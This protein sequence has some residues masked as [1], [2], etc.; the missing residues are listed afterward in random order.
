MSDL[1]T[2]EF[3]AARHAA[4]V[5]KDGFK[6]VDDTDPKTP[7]GHA[8]GFRISSRLTSD[9]RRQ[10]K[11]HTVDVTP[12]EVVDCLR[13]A[14]IKNWVL[15]GLHGYVGYLPMPRATQDVDV[16]VPL[17]QKKATLKAIQTQWPTLETIELPQV[18]RF[19]DPAD[20]LDG[21]PLPIIDVMLPLE[22]FQKT[23]LKKYIVEDQE[24]GTYVPTVEAA[25]VAKYAP[26][27]SHNRSWDKKQQDAIDFRRIVR[28]NFQRLDRKVIHDLAD[29][30]WLGGGAELLS[31][32]E[33]AMEDK[34]FPI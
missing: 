32:L 15:M 12:Q 10:Y 26:L 24:T 33:I 13:A 1:H 25:I 34:L 14:K 22:D 17:S 28:A 16:M 6:G 4:M 27:I 3:L 9:Y 29:Q 5:A 7:V 20:N 19:Y 23:I 11:R 31:F 8:R 21:K 30:I 2:P 18:V